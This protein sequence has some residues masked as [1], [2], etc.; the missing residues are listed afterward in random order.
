MIILLF[1][2]LLILGFMLRCRF[3][4][5]RESTYYSIYRNTHDS[6]AAMDLE[7]TTTNF[8]KPYSARNLITF[9]NLV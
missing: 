4:F 3:V 5:T 9:K 8:F 2:S 6:Q 7:A 1:I